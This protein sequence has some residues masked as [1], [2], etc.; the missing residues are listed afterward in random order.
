MAEGVL[1][2]CVSLINS[3]VQYSSVQGTAMKRAYFRVSLAL[4]KSSFWNKIALK[5]TPKIKMKAS[6]GT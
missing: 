1:P 2:E 5:E 6:M 3:M 4:P